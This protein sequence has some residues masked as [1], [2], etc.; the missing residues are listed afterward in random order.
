MNQ[1]FSS[2]VISALRPRPGAS[3]RAFSTPPS[4]YLFKQS[5]T[6]LRLIPT[7]SAMSSMEQ[8]SAFNSRM[9]ARLTVWAWIVRARVC[10]SRYSRSSAV[11]L[12]IL[13]FLPISTTPPSVDICIVPWKLNIVRLFERYY[14]S[15][16]VYDPNLVDKQPGIYLLIV[17]LDEEASDEKE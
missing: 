10:I 7:L 1:A 11:K 15:D 13:D 5:M 3:K 9:R 4:A 2:S 8:P 6:L 14:T 17:S 12:I 16:G